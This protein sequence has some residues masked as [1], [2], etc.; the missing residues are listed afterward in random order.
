MMMKLSSRWHIKWIFHQADVILVDPSVDENTTIFRTLAK[1]LNPTK[2]ILSAEDNQKLAFYHSASY[3]RVSV[4]IKTETVD[5]EI[6]FQELEPYRSFR[7]NF[8][9]KVITEYP[10]LYVVLKDHL[11]SYLDYRSEGHNDLFSELEGKEEQRMN[12]TSSKRMRFFDAC[13][14]DDEEEYK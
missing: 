12:G 6:V 5:S 14:D 10:V 2:N 8:A 7:V 9:N 11:E 3:S 4:L 13:S 1:Y